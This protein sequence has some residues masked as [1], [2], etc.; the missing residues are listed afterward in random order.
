MILFLELD[1]QII[2]NTNFL[3]YCFED[4]SRLEINYQMSEVFVMGSDEVEDARIAGM[5]NCNI[6]QL[7]LKYLGVILH[8]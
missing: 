3:L 2:I 8:N 7:P 5:F 1:D 4:M 6:G